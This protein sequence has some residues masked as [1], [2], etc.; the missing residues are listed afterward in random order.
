MI[1]MASEK[2]TNVETKETLEQKIQDCVA[3][4]LRDQ[5]IPYVQMYEFEGLLFSSPEA[6]ENNIQ[7]KGLSDWAKKY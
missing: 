7:Q 4:P 3:M 2:K 6:I 5:I 1:F